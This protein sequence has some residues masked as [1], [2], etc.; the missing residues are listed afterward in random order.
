[1]LVDEL[2]EF[3]DVKPPAVDT[4]FWVGGIT[5]LC[6]FSSSDESKTDS[7]PGASSSELSG[8]EA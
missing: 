5:I 3:I 8:E 2:R 6:S 1:M 4:R 7:C